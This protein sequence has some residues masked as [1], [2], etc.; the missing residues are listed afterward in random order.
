MKY[1]IFT[2]GIITIPVITPDCSVHSDISLGKEF[3][4]ISAGFLTIERSNKVII[5]MSMKSES[6]GLS[7]RIEDTSLLQRAIYDLGTM[8]F[9]NDML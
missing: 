8:F 2:N 5:N 7:P 1:V 4:A 9:T 3:K 6:T